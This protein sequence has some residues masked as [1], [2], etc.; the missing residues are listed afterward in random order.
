[1]TCPRNVVLPPFFYPLP[2]TGPGGVEVRLVLVRGSTSLWSDRIVWFQ[3][4]RWNQARVLITVKLFLALVSRPFFKQ[5]SHEP[6]MTT[7]QVALSH[8]TLIVLLL[9]I[10]YSYFLEFNRFLWNMIFLFQMFISPNLSHQ[11]LRDCGLFYQSNL[12]V[13]KIY[14]HNV[15]VTLTTPDWLLLSG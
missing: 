1:M 11:F 3:I 6:Q 14:S 15:I 2:Q 12:L 10:R 9:V 8:I 5:C 7:E 4:K 13:S